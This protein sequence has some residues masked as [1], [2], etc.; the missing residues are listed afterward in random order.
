MVAG[1]F[2]N[3]VVII[4]FW[5]ST[6]LQNKL[7]Y[8]MICVLSCFDLA[9]V[10]IIHPIVIWYSIV[11]YLGSHEEFGHAIADL[12]IMFLHMCSMLALV[13]LNI[14]RFLAL[15]YPFFH[16][17]S[18]T[19]RRVLL[20]LMTVFFLFTLGIALSF[21]S[22][23]IPVYT[24]LTAYFSIL[25]LVF[26]YL[27]YGILRIAKMKRDPIVPE[28][29][30]Q[31]D[32]AAKFRGLS[33]LR[34]IST[35]YLAFLCFIAVSVPSVIFCG[36]CSGRSA[37][38]KNICNGTYEHWVITVVTMNSTFNCLIFFWRNT[39]LRREATKVL[40]SYWTS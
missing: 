6:Q 34:N 31:N 18:V 14:E 38:N 7:C 39:I 26:L 13:T 8:F 5:R 17:I 35:C 25:L 29:P 24:L 20:F 16:Q 36:F 33:I 2:F 32:K 22:L 4:S 10:A 3:C 40:K 23:V 37:P 1:I 27:T 21:N 12:F 11:M 28:T 30:N 15:N 9:A 19:R